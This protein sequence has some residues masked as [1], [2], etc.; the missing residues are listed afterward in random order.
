MTDAIVRL[1]T[2]SLT[3]KEVDETAELGPL[4]DQVVEPVAAVITDLGSDRDHVFRTV[5]E[6]HRGAA[7]VVPPRSTAVSSPSAD[8]A[9]PQR[10]R[11]FHAITEQGRMSWQKSSG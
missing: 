8:T 2:T 7:V 3:G 9:P 1:V 5:S 11:H 6:R 4:L 10:D